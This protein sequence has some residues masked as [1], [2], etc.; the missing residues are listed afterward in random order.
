MTNCPMC[1][2][3]KL[4]KGTIKEEMFGIYLGT[5][6]ADICSACGESFTDEKIMKKI[7]IAAKKKGV[8]GLGVKTKI[9][10]AGNSLAIR[11]PQ[12]LVQFLNLKEGEETYLHP[13][14]RKL[15]MEP[16]K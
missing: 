1:E 14:S 9:A 12:K 2:K 3:G 4:K 11:I 6:P 13:E 15:V 10:K 5:F 16:M 7:E 8:W